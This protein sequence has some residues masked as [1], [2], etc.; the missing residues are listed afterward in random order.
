ML[1][2]KYPSSSGPRLPHSCQCSS[3]LLRSLRTSSSQLSASGR[4]D[5]VGDDI[6]LCTLDRQRFGEASNGSFSSTVIGLPEC[7]VHANKR[8][9]I[10]DLEDGFQFPGNR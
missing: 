4:K 5:C 2:P 6:I 8:R 1:D 9:S 10:D 3:H 7:T